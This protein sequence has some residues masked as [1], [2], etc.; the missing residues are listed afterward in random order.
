MQIEDHIAV[1]KNA[2]SQESCD[3]YIK[4]FEAGSKVNKTFTRSQLGDAAKLMKDDETLFLM[5]DWE[6]LSA[7]PNMLVGVMD[8]LGE[9]YSEYISVYPSLQDSCE[10]H[11]VF[12]MRLQ[13]TSIGGG[14]HAWHFE[15]SNR[16]NSRRLVAFM[17]YLNDVREGGETEFLYQHKRFK[18]ETGTLVIWP[19]TYTHTHRGNPPLSNDKYIITGWMEY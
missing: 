14:Y 6:L 2:M 13:K 15:K 17:F 1:F 19:A 18:P 5:T 16:E 8:A 7:R 3:Y 11:S 4:Y 12:S 10:K 9:K